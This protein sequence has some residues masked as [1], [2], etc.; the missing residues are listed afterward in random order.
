MQYL[1]VIIILKSEYYSETQSSLMEYSV[2]LNN[3]HVEKL[4]KCDNDFF[5]R[6][7]K[8]GAGTPVEGFDLATNTLHNTF[9]LL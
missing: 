4:E 7:F 6:L 5:R 8:S 9:A 1:L 2:V 3:S